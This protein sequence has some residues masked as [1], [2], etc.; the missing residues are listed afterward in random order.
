MTHSVTKIA[1]FITVTVDLCHNKR[2]KW[3]DGMWWLFFGGGGG[4][5]RLPFPISYF[6]YDQS[7]ADTHISYRLKLYRWINWR[8]NSMWAQWN[9]NS[10]CYSSFLTSTLPPPPPPKKNSCITT[11]RWEW[12]IV[13]YKRCIMFS[14][15]TKISLPCMFVRIN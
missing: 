9:D 6:R 4:E 11:Q 14:I 1:P 7:S 3:D 12:N 10:Y 8:N 5:G 15:N 13:G 2:L